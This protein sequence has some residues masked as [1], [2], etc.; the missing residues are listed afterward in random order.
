MVHFYSF[1]LALATSFFLM[2]AV[3]RLAN[4]LNLVDK[5]GERKVHTQIIPRIGGVAVVTSFVFAILL[6][7]SDKSLLPQANILKGITIGALIVGMVG[8]LDDYS[9]LNPYV[10]F[11][12][13]IVA[14][15]VAL[16]ISGLSITQIDVFGL[17]KLD[18]GIFSVPFTLLWIIG[19]T[20]SIN[21]MDG[22][23][24]LAAGIVS[25]AL[26]FIGLIGYLQGSY[27]LLF[28]SVTLIGSTLGFLKYNAHPAQ[29]F[30]GD[31]GSYFLGF[32]I[33]MLTL[34]GSFKSATVMAIALP[35]TILG[36][37]I[38]DTAWAFTRRILKGKNPFS[39]DKLHIHHRLMGLGL[40]HGLTVMFMYGIASILGIIAVLS[41]YQYKFRELSLLMVSV[42]MVFAAFKLVTFVRQQ[43]TLK[44]LF[45]T[46]VRPVPASLMFFLRMTL[47]L[48]LVIRNLIIVA[49]LLNVL[50]LTSTSLEGII[51]GIILIAGLIYLYL[52]SKR[53]WYEQF[54]MFILFLSGTFIIFTAE[55]VIDPVF[56][57][58]ISAEIF[59]N[60]LYTVIGI[61][62]FANIVIKRLSGN[63]LSN[64]FEFFI[65]L[66][67]VSLNLM[68]PDMAVKYHLAAVSIKSIILFLGYRLL[69]EYHLQRS[70]RIVYAT[71]LVI[72]FTISYS[73]LQLWGM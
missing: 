4:K 57:G 17:F 30:M 37:P 11:F 8:L 34:I 45:K 38:L 22:L 53:E 70:R 18:L 33:S 7:G 1:V 62:I 28:I 66:F 14:G 40:G 44:A 9:S 63:F 56:F 20:N 25:I 13:Q 72:V 3:I 43:P 59:S 29:V 35:L 51:I 19:I 26:F 42:F 60:I 58:T 31:V 64:P 71:F 50:I 47:F 39:P 61:L 10:K 73:S 32:V 68:P 67:V 55:Q 36:L 27:I 52:T 69:L 41:V 12:G 49:L 54:M 21:L 16:L 24:G 48:P 5:P 6:F 2:P 23:D 65:L 46:R 15:S